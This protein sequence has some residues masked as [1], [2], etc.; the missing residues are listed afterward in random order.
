MVCD[1]CFKLYPAVCVSVCVCARVVSTDVD[2]TIVAHQPFPEGSNRGHNIEIPKV[3][4]S[5]MLAEKKKERRI[6]KGSKRSRL[7]EK[8]DTREAKQSKGERR[9]KRKNK[10]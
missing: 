10:K 6:K 8:K 7:T 1:V 5:G 4:G 2:C 3:N 9:K